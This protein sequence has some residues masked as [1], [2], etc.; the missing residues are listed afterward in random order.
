MLDGL[1]GTGSAVVRAGAAR[2]D[3]EDNEGKPGD[4]ADKYA[5]SSSR[6]RST[7]SR[8]SCSPTSATRCAADRGATSCP[9]SSSPRPTISPSAGRPS[10][11]CAPTSRRASHARSGR[12][13]GQDP[14]YKTGRPPSR[15][16]TRSATRA[17]VRLPARSSRTPAVRRCSKTWCRSRHGGSRRISPRSEGRPTSFVPRI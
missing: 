6:T 8:A 5:S 11:S 10:G 12:L 15:W 2:A 4:R 3:R 13:R 1:D 14:Q 9:R 17:S 16:T 7:C